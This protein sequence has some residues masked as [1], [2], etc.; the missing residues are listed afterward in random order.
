MNTLGNAWV[1]LLGET[2]NGHRQGRDIYV[3]KTYEAAFRA[4]QR[5]HSSN[6]YLT[7]LY[8]A[9]FSLTSAP[10]GKDS[11]ANQHLKINGAKLTYSFFNGDVLLSRLDI[12]EAFAAETI[13]STGLYRSEYFGGNYWKVESKAK[14]SME[15]THRWSDCHYAAVSGR[16]EDKESA[17]DK[18]IDHIGRAYVDEI[19]KKDSHKKDNHYSLYWIANGEH[20]TVKNREHLTSLIQ[21]AADAK[22]PVNWLVHGEGTETFAGAMEVLQ[23]HPS[24]TR[25]E[26]KDGEIVR[27]LR[28]TLKKQQVYF[29]NP[30]GIKRK[31][32]EQLCANSGLSLKGININSQDMK[33]PDALQ[34]NIYKFGLLASA[35]LV[36]GPFAPS[37]IDNAQKSLSSALQAIPAPGAESVVVAGGTLAACLFISKNAATTVS[38]QFRA[39]KGIWNS[40]YG[41]AN[42]QWA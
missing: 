33:N 5:D 42:E 13:S 9:V 24:L 1:K 11:S 22:A 34:D 36:G 20:R 7:D 29:S 35:V 14:K 3:L 27:N 32:L 21:H 18:L 25:F 17:G 12:D 41:K 31:R 28:E 39:I 23:N 6:Y 26:A 38:G 40:T 30:R 37:G 8:R 19:R 2:T 10:A 4:L 16:F 15:L